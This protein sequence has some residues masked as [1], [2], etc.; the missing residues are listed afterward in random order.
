MKNILL[1]FAVVGLFLVAA[2]YSPTPVLAT[3][4]DCTA[5]GPGVDLSGCTLRF[6]NFA[7]VDMQNA[8]L[9]GAFLEYSTLN[10]V[11]LSN[12]SLVGANFGC[13][14][15]KATNF[16]F[17]DLR[18]SI[19]GCADLRGTNFYGADTTGVTWGG[20][21]YLTRPARMARLRAPAASDITVRRQPIR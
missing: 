11:N 12:A 1:M 13:A 2:L 7:G 10:N 5:R 6:V 16:S 15:L 4:P 18:N 19:M 20:N 3:S 14:A 9:D 17:A 21:L 8:N